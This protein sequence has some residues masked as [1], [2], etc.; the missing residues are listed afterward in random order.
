MCSHTLQSSKY[1]L[2]L[3]N[4]VS[5]THEHKAL[6]V[7]VHLLQAPNIHQSEEKKQGW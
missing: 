6:A 5:Q 7:H 3:K 1:I 4:V 2:L